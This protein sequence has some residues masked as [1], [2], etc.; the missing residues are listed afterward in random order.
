LG[1]EARLAIISPVIDAPSDRPVED[2]CRSDEA[3][4]VLGSV[5]GI[6]ALVPLEL[7]VA[8]YTAHG[9]A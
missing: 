5:S 4:A 8:R 6:L 1:N 7:H 9:H 3:D 2:A